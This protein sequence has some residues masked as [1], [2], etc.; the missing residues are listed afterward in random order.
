MTK[1]EIVSVQNVQ[2]Q[3]M[4][5]SSFNDFNGPL[6]VASL[7]QHRDLWKG[8]VMTRLESLICLRDIEHHWN[9]DTLFLTPHAGR[10]DE[11]LRLAQKWRADEVDW[12]GGEEACSLL[13]SYGPDTRNNPRQI[14]RVFWD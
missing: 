5:M 14:L 3:L 7:E 13:G 6:V 2:L 9:V 11:L 12:I 10:E 4:R 1:T 8:A